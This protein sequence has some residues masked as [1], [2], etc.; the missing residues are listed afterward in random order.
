LRTLLDRTLAGNCRPSLVDCHFFPA[1]LEL[2]LDITV[3]IPR[4]KTKQ[5]LVEILVPRT[6]GDGQQGRHWG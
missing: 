4:A 1:A 3:A 5:F 6:T 2:E